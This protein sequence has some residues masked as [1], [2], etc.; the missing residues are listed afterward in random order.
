MDKSRQE[1]ELRITAQTEGIQSDLNALIGK[2]DK[3]DR[4]MEKA[5]SG[6]MAGFAKMGAAIGVGTLAMQG[7]TNAFTDFLSNESALA[8]FSALT[9]VTGAALDNIGNKAEELSEKFGTSAVSNIEAMKGVLSRLGPDVAKTPEALGTMTEAVNTLAKASGLDATMSMDALTTAML[10]FNVSLDDPIAAS[11]E[12]TRMMN[13][14]AAG[15]K[16]GAAEVPD[17]A[18]ALKQAGVAAYGAN[19]GFEETT[20]ALEILAQGGKRGSEAGV[21]LR[22]VI[23][24]MQKPSKQAAETVADLGLD[25]AHLGETLTKQGLN[26]ALQ[27][28]SVAL[29]KTGSDAQK[30]AALA[31]L[32]GMEN[33]SAAGILLRGAVAADGQASA[34]D[35]LREKITGTNTA[36]EQAAVNMNTTSAKWDR[37]TA[38]ISNVA[39]G[40]FGALMSVMVPVGEW[41]VGAAPYLVAGAVAAAGWAVANT[42]LATSFVTAATASKAFIVG[43]ATNPITLW[44]AAIAGAGAALAYLGDALIVTAGEEVDMAEAQK[45]AADSAVKAK[46]AQIDHAQS[47]GT[48]AARYKELALSLQSGKLSTDEAKRAQAELKKVSSELN[49]EYPGLISSTDGYG[50]SLSKVDAIIADSANNTKRLQGE[51]ANL[52]KAQVE[53]MDRLQVTKI[54]KALEDLRGST[55]GIGGILVGE[56]REMTARLAGISEQIYKAW[57]SDALMR[58]QEDFFG[59]MKRGDV[60]VTQGMLDSLNAAISAQRTRIEALKG[61][62]KE[63]SKAVET[64]TTVMSGESAGAK[65]AADKTAPGSLAWLREQLS[66]LQKQMDGFSGDRMGAQFI[67]M[68]NKGE[69][70]SMQIKFM[71]SQAKLTGAELEKMPLAGVDAME[72]LPDAIEGVGDSLTEVEEKTISLTDRIANFFNVFNDGAGAAAGAAG[73]LGQSIVGAFEGGDALKATLKQLGN[74]IIAFVEAEYL[75]ATA[76]QFVKAIFTSGISL[77]SDMI[78][79][80]AALVALETGR[81]YMN[82]LA[83]GTANVPNDQIAQIHQGEMIVPRTFSEGIRRGDVAVTGGQKRGSRFEP[84]KRITG[85]VRVAVQDIGRAVQRDTFTTS[86]GVA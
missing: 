12:M 79:S 25:M 29:N 62:S 2:V 63:T 85:V 64:V 6:G 45:G 57:D 60:E 73:F 80:A 70:L 71:E 65:K 15:A 41:I 7:L 32:F 8:D 58:A 54:N 39:V 81:A 23:S 75:L 13:V 14:M 30:N 69:G 27:E 47:V 83:V 43:L 28:L 10:Q 76:A 18:D 53:A 3:L 37:F 61:T 19:L 84:A 5:T 44:V 46:Q 26:A 48:S 67:N 22:N 72:Q 59:V 42:G 20:A 82:S 9:G 66:E 4:S 74:T 36:S 38:T 31:R 78:W 77:T 86:Y 49:A 21:A 52:A 40:A 50:A 16:E 1:L 33:M 55:S 35:R 11:A 24:L 51:M 17:L 56:R 68:Q 34:M